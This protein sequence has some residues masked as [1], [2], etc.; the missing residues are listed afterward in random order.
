M[1]LI[2]CPN[3][4]KQI[5]EKAT[6]CIHCD[7][8]L[9]KKSEDII[10]PD[11]GANISK[12]VKVCPNCGCPIETKD[13]NDNTVDLTKV[14]KKTL[15]PIIIA[16]FCVAALIIGIVFF[17]LISSF[18]KKKEYEAKFEKAVYLM[19][20]GALEAE[21]VSSLTHDVWS[22][23]IYEKDSYLTDK[24]TKNSY[25][26]FWDDFNVSLAA[27]MLD[28]D[29]IADVEDIKKNQDEVQVLMKELKNP[30]KGYEDAYDAL[31]TYY[32][33]Y[34]KLVNLAVDPSGSLSSY[35]S[36]F[37]EADSEVA[38]TYKAVLLY[39]ED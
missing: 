6:K 28:K 3:C 2:N 13:S 27:L 23:T 22:N 33:A 1:A 12:D 20:D 34:T 8:E 10:C 11:C 18:V 17:V 39:I 37:N 25:G 15:L 35:S 38:N 30:P 32:E 7:F 9:N 19:F 26:D 4:G 16:I 29:Y 31:K 21:S 5:S 24:Y 36:S 14:K